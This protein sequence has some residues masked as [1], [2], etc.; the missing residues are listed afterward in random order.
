MSDSDDV[1]DTVL[2][3]ESYAQAALSTRRFYPIGLRGK[4]LLCIGTVASTITIAPATYTRR[5]L[6]SSLEG[7]A[8]ATGTVAPSLSII[9][10]AGVISTTL[11]A[12]LLLRFLWLVEI[13]A[14]SVEQAIE[15][16]RIEEA[17]LTFA[18]STGVVVA[19]TSVILSLVGFLTPDLA[20]G[21][22]ASGVRIYVQAGGLFAIDTQVTSGLA[23]AITL[24]LLLLYL[25][26]TGEGA[27]RR[28]TVP[29]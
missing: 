19:A 5:D 13:D 6:I 2:S 26:I 3:G 21:L 25:L 27:R 22:Y 29:Q 14:L 12:V 9:A 20:A 28:A 8:V 7:N 24:G 4:V 23:V 15:V 16:I 17:I 18:I 1:T 10:L 11:C